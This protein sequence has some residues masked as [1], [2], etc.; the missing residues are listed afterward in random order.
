MY[1]Y[2]SLDQFRLAEVVFLLFDFPFSIMFFLPTKISQK[3]GQACPSKIFL[4]IFRYND[5][6]LYIC[7]FFKKSL[8]GH[9]FLPLVFLCMSYYFELI[10]QL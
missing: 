9:T 5:Q 8:V 6:R 3:R 7:Y 4:G 2:L 1:I 10:L